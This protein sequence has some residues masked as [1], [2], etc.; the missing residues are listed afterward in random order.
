[1]T[2]PV[3]PE[4]LTGLQP[5]NKINNENQNLTESNAHPYRL[6]I[7]DFAPF[8]L[9]NLALVHV[10]QSGNST[11]LTFGVHYNVCLKYKGASY[12]IGKP[13]YGGLTINDLSING[14]IRVSY[15]TLGGIWCGDPAYVL[16]MLNEM[17][18]NPRIASWDQ[19]T[20]VQQTFPPTNHDQ[21]FEFVYGHRELIES[22][23]RVAQAV[24]NRPNLEQAQIVQ[25]QL[26]NGLNRNRIE[27][28]EQLVQDLHPPVTP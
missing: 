16:E 12:S 5:S 26:D 6:I 11:P 21:A 22:I 27:A 4:D 24:A 7:P 9:D 3:Y 1:M 19:V 8:H 23:D 13:I 17:A 28:L 2:S 18:Y 10:D 15:Q 20:N 14:H 25:L